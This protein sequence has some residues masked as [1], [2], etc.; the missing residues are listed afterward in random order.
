[1]TLSPRFLDAIAF[2]AEAHGGQLRKGTGIPYLAH[3]LAVAALALEHG[4]DEDQAIS[5]LLH[6]VI[7]DCG[8]HHAEPIR[9]RFGEDVLA[10]IMGCTDSTTHPKPPWEDRKRAYVAHVRETGART[11]LVSACD[12]VHNLR[13]LIRDE[14]AH[15]PAIWSRF[16]ATRAQARWYYGALLEAFDKIPAPLRDEYARALAEFDA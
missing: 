12:K 13:A 16:H 8:L 11:Q 4:A 6:D 10:I 1:M 5:A 15:G 2:A 9:E 3:L 14:R 7:E